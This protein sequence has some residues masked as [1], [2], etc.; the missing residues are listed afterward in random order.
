[1]IQSFF[2]V[3]TVRNNRPV[4]A[5]LC[6]EN[7][8]V[9]QA[10]SVSVQIFSKVEFQPVFIL[11]FCFPDFRQNRPDQFLAKRPVLSQIR[12]FETLMSSPLALVDLTCRQH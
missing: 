12:I 9:S 7:R 3:T 1:M 4:T 11:F 2:F 6:Q 8:P 10:K 5:G